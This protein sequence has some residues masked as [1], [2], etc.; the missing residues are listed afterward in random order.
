[1]EVYEQWRAFERQSDY[2]NLRFIST[3]LLSRLP[4]SSANLLTSLL[5]LLCSAISY[6]TKNGCTPH[7]MAA[8]FG[9]F[10]FGLCDDQPFEVTYSGFVKVRYLPR[11]Y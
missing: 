11:S 6:T 7:R 4:S 5:D 3:H 10:I 8:L 9:P 2:T 1:M